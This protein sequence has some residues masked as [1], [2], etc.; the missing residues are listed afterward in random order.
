[1][2][3]MTE[4]A[5]QQIRRLA[6]AGAVGL[7]AQQ[8]ATA[9]VIVLANRVVGGV[10]VYELAWTVF[11]VPWAVLA[12]PIATSVFP[13]LTQSAAAGDE[14]AFA[15]S[16]AVAL[17][18][19]V[20]TMLLATAVLVATA[21]PAAKLLLALMHPEPGGAGAPD[22]ARAI[23]AFA[24]GLLGYGVV[25]LLTRA[26]Y[27]RHAGRAAAVATVCGFAVTAAV[28]VALASVVP[29][30]WL[31]AAMGAGNSAGMTVAAL[32]LLWW[33]RRAAGPPAAA[34]AGRVGFVC[35]GAAFAGAG[36][37]AVLATLLPRGD[38]P[39]AAVAAAAGA[40][41]TA[42]VFGSIAAVGLRTQL[43]SLVQRSFRRDAA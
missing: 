22:L 9:V 27:A 10:I 15:A 1:M 24:P 12:V 26:A 20:L 3:R 7:G 28:D 39:Q 21:Q 42:V 14:D 29:R 31:V 25:A 37:G 11:M 33:L 43:G 17:R 16:S 34:G 2:L 40:V 36:G 30:H 5:G 41:A 35:G 6:A 18:A 8:L 4:G 32:A 23:A 19:V 38:A 13:D